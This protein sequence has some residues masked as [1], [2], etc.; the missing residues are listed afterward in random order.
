MKSTKAE[1]K[2]QTQS[3]DGQSCATC[4]MFRPPSG[5][6]AVQGVVKRG[7]WCRYYKQ[8]KGALSQEK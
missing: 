4:T 6:T 8:E 3:R 5:C 2:Y 1:A 7:G